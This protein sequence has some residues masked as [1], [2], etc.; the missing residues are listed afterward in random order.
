MMAPI[1]IHDSPAVTLCRAAMRPRGSV[2]RIPIH[3][4]ARRVARAQTHA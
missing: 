2:T 4:A 1:S 3:V